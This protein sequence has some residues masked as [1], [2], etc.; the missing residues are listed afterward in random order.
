MDSN[1]SSPDSPRTDSTDLM[2]Y[3]LL[4]RPRTPSNLPIPSA[5]LSPVAASL[6]NH[7]K[8]ASRAYLQAMERESYDLEDLVAA[9]TDVSQS[10]AQLQSA[11]LAVG[12]DTLT[13]VVQKRATHPTI[14][15]LLPEPRSASTKS[16]GTHSTPHHARQLSFA[17]PSRTPCAPTPHAAPCSDPADPSSTTDFDFSEEVRVLGLLADETVCDDPLTP[18]SRR[19]YVIRYARASGRD[20]VVPTSCSAE[21]ELCMPS[22]V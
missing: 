10:F 20:I 14:P 16:D 11:L 12:D 2:I 22:P 5:H 6:R 13:G 3:S 8:V 19:A 1:A 7:A 21:V 4:H 18:R 17:T 15:A 9:Y